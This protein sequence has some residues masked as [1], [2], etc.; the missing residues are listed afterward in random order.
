MGRGLERRGREQGSCHLLTLTARGLMVALHVVLGSGWPVQGQARGAMAAAGMRRQHGRGGQRAQ[1]DCGGPWEWLPSAWLLPPMTH[2]MAVGCLV[3]AGCRLHRLL[4]WPLSRGG[5]P[6]PRHDRQGPQTKTRLPGTPVLGSA[7][8]TPGEGTAPPKG[9]THDLRAPLRS[10]GPTLRDR[11]F[12]GV[13]G[14]RKQTPSQALTRQ[15][16]A[17]AGT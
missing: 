4:N 10:E 16:K 7:T 12:H 6:P 5:N 2:W 13:G 3:T 15:R 1:G 14:G 17:T 9:S 11:G 8:R